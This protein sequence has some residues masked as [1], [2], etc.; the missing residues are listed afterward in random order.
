MNIKPILSICLPCFGRVDYVRNTL[1]SIYVDNSDVPLEKF[2]VVISDNDPDKEVSSLMREF[3]YSNL[4]YH[5]S[6]CEGFLNSYYVLT[7]GN[8][9]LLKLH[10]SQVLFRR[11]SLRAI[12]NEVEKVKDSK[13]LIFYSNGLLN[14]Y[15]SKMYHSFDDYYN[16]LSYWPSWSNGFSIWKED[17]D[18]LISPKLN[19]LFPHVSLFNTQHDKTTF[20]L[21]DIHLFD[22]QRV[23]G[24]KGHNKFE[25]FTIEYPSLVDEC[26]K[27]GWISKDTEKIIFN[28]ILTEYLP[29]LLFNKYIA[30]IEFYDISG[31]KTN[32]K[33]YFPAGAYWKAWMYVLAVPFKMVIRRVRQAL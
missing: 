21:N 10:N 11:G 23:R 17:Y 29:T 16:H 12:I 13:P 33:K 6:D 15:S 28:D 4:H 27:K 31:Y 1:K 24:R 32:I 14:S 5:Y 9:D 2:E 22:T 26:C 7:Y 18:K 8:G 20:I 30:R 19:K 25:A 3:P